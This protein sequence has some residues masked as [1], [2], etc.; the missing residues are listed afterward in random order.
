MGVAGVGVAGVYVHLALCAV[1]FCFWH[2]DW[3]GEGGDE[4]GRRAR[5]A[6]QIVSRVVVE[7][8][9]KKPWE[10]RQRYRRGPAV[11]DPVHVRCSK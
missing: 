5:V 3:V 9:G 2:S 8:S 10:N 11:Q 7:T 1:Q 6:E 4:R